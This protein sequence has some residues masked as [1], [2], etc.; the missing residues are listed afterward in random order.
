M[1]F[2]E[3]FL[4][5]R[6]SH[7]HPLA[8]QKRKF[9]TLLDSKWSKVKFF[10]KK[11]DTPWEMPLF[12]TLTVYCS[13]IAQPCILPASSCQSVSL[14]M[15]LKACAGVRP[16]FAAMRSTCGSYQV[17]SENSNNSNSF[18][19]LV[20]ATTWITQSAHVSVLPLK[21][22]IGFRLAVALGLSVAAATTRIFSDRSQ[23]R[24]VGLGGS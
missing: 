4:S 22:S 3:L 15:G 16:W 8:H 2:N 18:G 12:F 14:F 24:N 5:P 19:L 1:F 9:L 7:L 10:W 6:L 11:I 17:K 20:A 21:S 23:R 13:G